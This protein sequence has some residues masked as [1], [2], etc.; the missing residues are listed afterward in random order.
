VGRLLDACGGYPLARVFA[1]GTRQAADGPIE[2][3]DSSL[4][5]TIQTAATA[6]PLV[7]VADAGLV[8]SSDEWLW[9]MAGLKESFDDAVLIGGRLVDRDGIIVSPDA[10]RRAD[11]P[12]YFGTALKQRTT[13]AVTLRLAAIDAEWV[14]SID[15]A[16]LD[17]AG[18]DDLAAALA[19]AARES[20][21]RIVISPFIE[22]TART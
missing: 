8:P 1:W 5:R 10:G 16:P 4:V 9:E 20:K 19:G 18:I 22:A 3:P 17:D 13:G 7:A 2:W 15:P 6:A 21:G 12:G 11:D 14:R